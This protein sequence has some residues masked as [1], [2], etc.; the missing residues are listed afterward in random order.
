[1]LFTKMPATYSQNH[2]RNP[3]T[4]SAEK[5]F[6]NIVTNMAIARERFRKYIPEV[7]LSTPGR[8]LLDNGSLT[9]IRENE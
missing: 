9:R 4:V 1:M 6:Q 5:L 7:T 2:T 8:P 3:Y